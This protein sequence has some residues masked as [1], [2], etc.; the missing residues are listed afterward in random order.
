MMY[1]ILC[2]VKFETLHRV[3]QKRAIWVQIGF[4]VVVNW[5]FAP[6]VMVSVLFL[7]PAGWL[8]DTVVGISVGFSS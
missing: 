4:S 6:L 5:I 7:G 3:F 8:M 2:K 1:P